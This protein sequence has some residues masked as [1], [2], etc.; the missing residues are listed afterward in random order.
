[1]CQR[2]NGYGRRQ[3]VLDVQ[4]GYQERRQ[5]NEHFVANAYAA[6]GNAGS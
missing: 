3:R 4:L 5:W 2:N 1:M 6:A